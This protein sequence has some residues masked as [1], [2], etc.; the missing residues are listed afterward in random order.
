MENDICHFN[1]LPAELLNLIAYFLTCDDETE[2]QFIA[3]TLA[4]KLETDRKSNQDSYD[5]IVM[6]NLRLHLKR[7]DKGISLSNDGKLLSLSYHSKRYVYE[8]LVKSD[9]ECC[10]LSLSGNVIAMFHRQFLPGEEYRT[11][12]LELLKVRTEDVPE[13][14]HGKLIVEERREL[15]RADRNTWFTEIAFNKQGNQ[16]IGWNLYTTSDKSN[17]KIF[18]LKIGDLEQSQAVVKPTN[19]L[20]EYLRDKFVCQQYIEGRK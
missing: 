4:K 20:Q 1:K 18:S 9:Y 2:E 10:D 5:E 6:H 17:H 19:K 15:A 16:L 3:R 11:A 12:I 7:N 13:Q 8:G 14:K